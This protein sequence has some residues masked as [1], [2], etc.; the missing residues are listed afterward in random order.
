[1]FSPQLPFCPGCSHCR[2]SGIGPEA[3]C[4]RKPPGDL[5]LSVEDFTKPAVDWCMF[6]ANSGKTCRLSCA[7][8]PICRNKRRFCRGPASGSLGHSAQFAENDSQFK[9]S[10]C[11]IRP[12]P[13][14]PKNAVEHCSFNAPAQ[15]PIGTLDECGL[16]G[17]A[18]AYFA[19]TF[20]APVGSLL[21]RRQAPNRRRRTA[22]KSQGEHPVAGQK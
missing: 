19:Q 3:P 17:Q 5:R 15:S 2:Y 1:M 7:P 10:S 21:R 12:K 16:S 11:S 22:K 18:Q 4:R 20:M 6:P 14:Q 9:Q 13:A 8:L